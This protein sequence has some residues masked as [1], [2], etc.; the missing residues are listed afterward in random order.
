MLVRL[1]V[2]AG[3]DRGRA[4][5]LSV[6]PIVIGRGRDT[7]T[8]LNDPY[9]SR[10]HARIEMRGTDL[11]LVALTSSS[12]TFVNDE[13]ISERIL[14]LGDVIRIGDTQLRLEEDIADQTTLV[15]PDI[16]PRR[17]APEGPSP[18][19]LAPTREPGPV[20]PPRPTKTS[21]PSPPTPA[22]AP[23]PAKPQAKTP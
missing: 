9:V 18:I 3:P 19:E 16:R 6:F 15:P 21:A 20:L 5:S 22:P 4:V 12:G 17:S 7:D 2:I 10:A 8:C 11:T 23:S 1:L 14:H 13:R